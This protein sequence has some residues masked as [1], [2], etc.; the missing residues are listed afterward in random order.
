MGLYSPRQHALPAARCCSYRCSC[1][2]FR[3]TTR[4]PLTHKAA[5]TTTATVPQASREGTA[6][7][8]PLTPLRR[9]VSCLRSQLHEHFV[10][11]PDDISTYLAE[12]K[13]QLLQL[14]EWPEVGRCRCAEALCCQGA[15]HFPNTHTSL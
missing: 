5:Y 3:I 12:M 15:L 2:R 13:E 10:S 9:A 6:P 8:S 1:R 7:V 14:V 4:V 11:I